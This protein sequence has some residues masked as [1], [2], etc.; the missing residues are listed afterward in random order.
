MHLSIKLKTDLQKS[1]I[2]FVYFY[3]LMKFANERSNRFSNY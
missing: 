3:Y 1:I 2:E